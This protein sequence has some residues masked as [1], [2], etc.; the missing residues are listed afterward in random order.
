MAYKIALQ[1]CIWD[2][3]ME[4]KQS[5]IIKAYLEIPPVQTK[6][7]AKLL[8]KSEAERRDMAMI[9]NGTK[10]I[11]EDIAEDIETGIIREDVETLTIEEV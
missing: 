10:A 4:R 5:A 1:S 9:E 8:L 11:K 2:N 3:T 7:D 6:A